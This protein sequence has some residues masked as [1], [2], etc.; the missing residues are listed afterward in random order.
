MA[1]IF[2]LVLGIIAGYLIRW[3]NERL[4][5]LEEKMKNG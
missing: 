3:Q 5:K 1:E 2:Y 4:K